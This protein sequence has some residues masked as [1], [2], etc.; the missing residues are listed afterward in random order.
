MNDYYKTLGLTPTATHAEVKHA[1]RELTKRFHPDRNAHRTE[2]ATR[3]MQ[4]LIEAHRVLSNARLRESYDRQ[5]R[6]YYSRANA[7]RQ[8]RRY[9]RDE[10]S[11]AA[12]AER[13]LDDLLNGKAAQ[14]IEAY[15]RLQQKYQGFELRDHLD[16]RDWVDAKFLIAEAYQQQGRYSEALDLYES[17]YHS[18][19]ARKRCL[20]YIQEVRDRIFKIICRDMARSLEPHAAVRVL[21]RALALDLTKGE[22]AFVHKKIAESY[23]ASGDQAAARE[24]LTI[25]FRYKPDLKGVT[26]VCNRLGFDPAIVTEH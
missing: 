9:S 11:L 16:L 3:Q 10:T 12:Q 8:T 14:A 17:L 21:E 25:A 23:L 24:H 22:R 4:R 2:W 5:L 26:K 19:E 1:F 20:H 7:P 18:E 6:L 13:I 15:E